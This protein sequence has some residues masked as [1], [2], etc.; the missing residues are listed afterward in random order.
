[1]TRQE[2]LKMVR[3]NRW[4][5][6]QFEFAGHIYHELRIAGSGDCPITCAARIITGK[7]FRTSDFEY[8]A[9]LIGLERKEAIKLAEEA[10]K[11]GHLIISEM[12]EL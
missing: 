6:E 7:E 4:F 1:M 5:V 3:D 8:A 2:L 12:S 9:E 11:N 10:D